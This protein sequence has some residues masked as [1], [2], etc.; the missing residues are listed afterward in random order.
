MQM[1][2]HRTRLLAGL[3]ASAVLLSGLSASPAI[4]MADTATKPQQQQ[5]QTQAK[6][7]TKDQEPTPAPSDAGPSPAPAGDATPPAASAS[8][9]D[10]IAQAHDT[11]EHKTDDYTKATLDALR[12][13]L[14]K[15]EALDPSAD[16]QATG[17]AQSALDQAL[18]ALTA[19]A[20]SADGTALAW[21]GSQYAGT[22]GPL[23]HEP[24]ASV[25]ASSNDTA[26]KPVELQASGKPADPVSTDLGVI[27]YQGAR[28]YT[29]ASG[30]GNRPLAFS[31]PYDYQAG[32]P[33]EVL[34]PQGDPVTWQ[35]SGLS[36]QAAMT[37]SLDKANKPATQA[38]QVNGESIPITWDGAVD[39]HD[40][41]TARTYTRTG[42]ASGTLSINGVEQAW[43]VSLVAS[44]TEG[45]VASL[46]VLE[47][48]ADGAESQHPVD[49]FNPASLEYSLTLPYGSMTSQF[50]LGYT[51][52]A[53]D[54]ASVTE[55]D[56]VRP[57]LGGD[58]SRILGITLDGVT[59]RVTVRFAPPTPDAS[60]SAA[61]LAGIYV[62]RDGTTAKGALIDGWNPDVLDYTI[63]IAADAPSVYVLPEAGDG[64][65][66]SAADVAQTAYAVRQTWNVTAANGEHRVYTVT[67]VRDHAPTAAEGFQPKDPKDTGGT[68]AAKSDKE[69]DVESH[70][71]IDAKGAYHTANANDYVIEE[72]GTFAYSSY[73]GQTIAASVRKIAQMRYEYTLSILAPDGVTFAR[74]TYT[75][76]YLTEATHRVSVTGILV[77]NKEISGFDPSRHEYD[78]TV[79]TLDHWT[80][81]ATFDKTSGMSITI[82]KEHAQA[83]I[84]AVS[85][86]GLTRETYTVRV[87]VAAIGAGENG[88][89]QGAELANTG[90][91]VRLPLFAAIGGTIIG[92]LLLG[93]GVL[94]RRRSGKEE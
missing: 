19:I 3:A 21:D 9:A 5:T 31:Q 48:T 72:G 76:T 27:R 40:T 54:S 29:G 71:W 47:R 7:Q 1:G 92:L 16:E 84:T 87:H 36:V 34:N 50:A 94:R 70:G 46:S 24:A 90:S 23:D 12:D 65:S 38:I 22:A 93:V 80:V 55:G 62:N 66:V 2:T 56:P 15:A 77:D 82:H 11:L 51:S 33:I 61:R 58:G 53:G 45:K 6:K 83:V 42:T 26:L 32:S 13:A 18:Q 75:V 41:D 8:L 59:Y 64:V 35:P 81:N 44:R 39:V 49:G 73:A 78:A 57:G 63:R 52:A 28:D 68:S 30:N 4:A 20:W 86:D 69:T 89:V 14:G 17:Q 43:S 37:A 85:A 67:V 79:E 10:L 88:A 74:H 25:T 91:N 60:N